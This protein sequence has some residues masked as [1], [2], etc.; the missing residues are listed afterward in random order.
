[1][2]PGRLTA[3][4]AVAFAAASFG[5]VPCV[6]T[7]Q[8]TP[9]AANPRSRALDFWVGNW[10]IAAPGGGPAATS[11]VRLELDKC[12]VIERWNGGGE[13]GINVFGYSSGDQTW[14][15]FFANNQGHVHAFLDGRVAA[16]LA[17]FTGPNRG[18]GGTIILNRIS[19]RRL[20]ANRVEQ[21][22]EKSS[23]G[24]KTWTTLFQLEYT[25]KPHSR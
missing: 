5:C 9:C 17:E 1:M 15:G 25:R 6:M 12:V 20:S 11:R 2:N 4:L 7:A 23:D 19:I 14:H 13:T 10:A 18:P 21:T 24:G 16:G 22:W 3:L 8:D